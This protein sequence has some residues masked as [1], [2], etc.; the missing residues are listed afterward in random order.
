MKRIYVGYRLIAPHLYDLVRQFHFVLGIACYSIARVL[1]PTRKSLIAFISTP[2]FNDSALAIYERIRA[3]RPSGEHRFVWL[4]KNPA[5]W[6]SKRDSRVRFVKKNSLQG[7]WLFMRSRYVFFTHRTYR[8][9]RCPAHQTIVNLWH[10][11]PVKTTGIFV[12]KASALR[13]PYSGYA[14]ATSGFFATIISKAFGVPRSRVLVSGLP[15]NEWLFSVDRRHSEMT[16]DGHKFVVWLPTFREYE[17]DGYRLNDAS[18][19]DAICPETLVALDQALDR[20]PVTVLL[21]FHPGDVRNRSEW[22]ELRNIRIMTG[23]AFQKA[24]LN[25]YKLLACSDGLITDFSSIAIDYLIT[26]KPIAL[27][28]ADPTNYHR[29]VIPE[30]LAKLSEASF[31]SD[32]PD[33][34][35]AYLKSLSSG[36]RR[37]EAADLLHQR[38][39]KDPT[40]AI[41]CSVGLEHL[42]DTPEWARYRSPDRAQTSNPQTVW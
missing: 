38:D 22:P 21:K 32:T 29:G 26:G 14:V 41:L 6:D 18:G 33:D 3:A 19:K 23:A 39:L 40:R 4:V 35:M 10:G 20:V 17:V 7:L 30:V 25:V 31:K 34:L 16:R 24:G 2:D 11:M 5:Q 37:T 13:Q 9:A 42:V 12:S 1:L 15:R 27:Y 28:G 36:E 8:F